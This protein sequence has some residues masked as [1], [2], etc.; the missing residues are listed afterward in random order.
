MTSTILL[1][2]G[3]LAAIALLSS[4]PR[5]PAPLRPLAAIGAL[6][7]LVAGFTLASVR[8]VG[9]DEVGVVIK[10]VGFRSLPEGRIIAVDGEKGPQARILA[11]GW[12]PW[13]WPI[14]YDVEIHKQ[15]VIGP[16]EVGLLTTA[17]GK[18]LP[19]GEVFAP[20][21]SEDE[22]QRML[23]AEY[24]LTKGGGYKGPQTS[25]LTPGR[26]RVNPKLFKVEKAPVTN[27]AQATVGVVKSNVGPIPSPGAGAD[28]A[29][30]LVDKGQRG[31]W[32]TP[33]QPQKYYLNT[34]AY[35]VTSVST[36]KR[37]VQY[38]KSSRE[39]EEREITVR[40]S[41]GFTFPVDVRV[42][43]EIRPSDAPLVVANFQDDD[44][45][46]LA[47]RLHSA[48]RAIFRNNAE[49]VNALDY[50]NNRS[51]QESQSLAMLAQ[52]MAPQGLTVTAVRIGDVG[53][54]QTLGELL[55]TQTDREIAKQQQITFQEQQRA[56]EQRK[57]LTRTEQE[58][59]EE[60]RLATAQYQVQIAE[61]ARQQRVIEAQAQA[62]AIRVEAEAQ[63][64]AFA[65]IAREIGRN[66]AA[67][68]ELLKI[69]GDK[70]VQITPR[71][72]VVG[73][74]G[75]RD[76][77]GAQTTALIGTMLDAMMKQAEQEQAEGGR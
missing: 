29:S 7:A 43:Y 6:V 25:V 65:A 8:Y 17:D 49:K 73:D 57:A 44:S 19:P 55:K 47:G 35:E 24:F 23:D 5:A 10:N 48:V 34:R 70:G 42:E 50:V 15:V 2:G 22:F 62:E 41:D 77:G 64:Q 9:D 76:A 11:P 61:Q 27:I 71:V 31:I 12:H 28:A 33:L 16:D 69:V 4:I 74:S 1:L 32:R 52:E 40:S 58:A 37:T 21:W 26:Y 18:P 60:K 72:M 59:E 39:G 67:L 45:P 38:T 13:L 75:S 30:P 3:V 68:I 54:E 56:A 63:A 20:A 14:I 51:Q 66:N 53:D 46:A 36:A